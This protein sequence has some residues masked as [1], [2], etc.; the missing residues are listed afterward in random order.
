MSVCFSIIGILLAH[1][2]SHFRNCKI[3]LFLI[4]IKIQ[5]PDIQDMGIILSKPRYHFVRH[6]FSKEKFGGFAGRCNTWCI[7]PVKNVSCDLFLVNLMSSPTVLYVMR[8]RVNDNNIGKREGWKCFLYWRIQHILSTVIWCRTYGK[9]P[10]CGL[11][12]SIN[13]KDS[14]ISH[15]KDSTY[16]GLGYTSRGAIAGAWNSSLW[17][18]M[19][20]RSHDLSHH[21][22]TMYHAATFRSDNNA[23]LI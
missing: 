20:D 7:I 21:E 3:I 12:F 5:S 1:V 9:G 18:T 17:S 11:L 6:V 10:L 8:C 23:H 15:R 2:S 22:R 4:Q 14:F 16:H 19:R 13:S